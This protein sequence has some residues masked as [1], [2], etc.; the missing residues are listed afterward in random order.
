MMASLA[1]PDGKSGEW[2]LH[3]G[4]DSAGAPAI[5]SRLMGRSECDLDLTLG[6]GQ[7]FRWKRVDPTDGVAALAG[8]G[9]AG[10]AP[11]PAQPC[12]EA[13]IRGRLVGFWRDERLCARMAPGPFDG[14]LLD[15]YLDTRIRLADVTR[16]IAVDPHIVEALSRYPG[17][18]IV[19]QEPWETLISFILSQWSNVPRISSQVEALSRRYGTE[20]LPGRYAFPR[21]DQLARATVDELRSLGLGYRAEYVRRAARKCDEQGLDWL[22]NL[23]GIEY[24]TARDLIVR[25]FAPGRPSEKVHGVGAKVADCV[26]LFSLGHYEAVP[27]DVHVRRAMERWYGDQATF[28]SRYDSVADFGRLHFGRYAGYAQQ[29]LFHR[30]REGGA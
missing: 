20:I 2:T 17:L 14:S 15:H 23:S 6:C 30:Q 22:Q 28:T 5:A 3:N 21:P 12:W 11:S 7:A 18:R 25:P 4:Q 1:S 26:L 29:Y 27:V 16:E 13:V 10:G 24:R 9:P 19:Q 8:D